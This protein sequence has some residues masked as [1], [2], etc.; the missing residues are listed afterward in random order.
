MHAAHINRRCFKF[1]IIFKSVSFLEKKMFKDHYP[2]LLPSMLSIPFLSP[3]ASAWSFCS[4]LSGF[5]QNLYLHFRLI[6]NEHFKVNI[7]KFILFVL[8]SLKVFSWFNGSTN[9]SGKTAELSFFIPVCAPYHW[10]LSPLYW[11]FLGLSSP[12][13]PHGNH[14]NSATHDLFFLIFF[15]YKSSFL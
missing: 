6:S 15:S 1:L 3:M 13:F 4:S 14:H 10:S 9:C 5:L 2:E 8:F 11:Y 7:L 12:V